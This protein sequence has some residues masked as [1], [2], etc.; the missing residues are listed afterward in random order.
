MELNRSYANRC[1]AT[2]KHEHP[3][4]SVK[5]EIEGSTFAAPNPATGHSPQPVTS[6]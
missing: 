1:L 3:A 6:T 4:N 5:V 2:V